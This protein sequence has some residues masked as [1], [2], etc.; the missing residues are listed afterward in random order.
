MKR[1]H[2]S[3]F[4]IFARYPLQDGDPSALDLFRLS[5][6]SETARMMWILRCVFNRLWEADGFQISLNCSQS[7]TLCSHHLIRFHYKTSGAKSRLRHQLSAF[8]KRKAELSNRPSSVVGKPYCPLGTATEQ[9]RTWKRF[10]R[11][12]ESSQGNRG[13]KTTKWPNNSD[14]Q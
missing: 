14:V 11:W 5:K 12:E 4:S 10:W 8:W 13:R 1:L 3:I 6:V 7:S 9:R 2:G